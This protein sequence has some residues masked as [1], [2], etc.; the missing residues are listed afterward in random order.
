MRLR[1]IKI[2]VL[3]SLI[4]NCSCNI[5]KGEELIHAPA[6]IH[7]TSTV[8]DGKYT[9]SEIARIAKQN[10]IKVVIITDHDLMRW[11]YGL[12][13]LRNIIKRTVESNSVFFRR[14][15]IPLKAGKYGIGRYLTEINKAQESNPGLVLITGV[16]SSPFYYW[17]GSPFNNSLKMHNW[18][19]K[20]LVIGLDEVSDYQYLPLIGNR[21]ALRLPFR[22]KD[23]YR[24]WPILILVAGILCLR[25]R[26]FK[27]KDLK[28]QTLGPYSRGWR[29]SGI[30]LMLIG[31][32]FSWNNY[33]FCEFKFDQ[34]HGDLGIMPYQNFIDYVNQKG[35]LTYWASPEAEYIQNRG[36]ISIETREY[37]VDLL[38]ARDY[39]G[40][41][42]FFEGYKKVGRPGG[43][44]DEILNQYCQGK[45]REPIWAIAGLSFS[46]AGDL[47]SRITA[48]QTMTLVSELSKTAVL[49]ALK[50]GRMYAISGNESSY[51]ILDRFVIS[52][53]LS[54]AEVTM[55]EEINL[56][57][58]PTI[59]IKGKFLNGLNKEVK[60]KLIR[61]GNIVKTFEVNSPFDISYQ[62]DYEA[63][64][65]KIYY[66]LE[67]RSAG[68]FLVTNPI[69]VRS[70]KAL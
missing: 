13:P 57:G 69:F 39:T 25:R 40:F 32:L 58:N 41:A 35:G 22:L 67:I 60:I 31:F 61:N 23:V 29:I 27:Y 47:D 16:K 59:E 62:D 68:V 51:F 11:E 66:R 65:E 49:E 36:N 42:I 28:G 7:I 63:E 30:A 33:P 18:H 2:I 54:G 53:A 19:K 44:W 8:S 37:A 56:T 38:K 55:G 10:N 12:W 1:L 4:L 43:I 14:S 46:Q 9:I 34:Y 50:K 21:R 17:Q 5:G 48:S 15:G 6:A 20:I 70:K 64:D 24:L 52:D 3:V 26:K 45:R